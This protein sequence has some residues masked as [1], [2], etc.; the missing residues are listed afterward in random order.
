[1]TYYGSHAVRRDKNDWDWVKDNTF[2]YNG[3]GDPFELIDRPMIKQSYTS[4]KRDI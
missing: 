2:S 3:E 4:R 1:M